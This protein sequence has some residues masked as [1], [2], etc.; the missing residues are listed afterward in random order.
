MLNGLSHFLGLDK[1]LF[2]YNCSLIASLVCNNR[3]YNTN[4]KISDPSKT[5]RKNQQVERILTKRFVTMFG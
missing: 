3:N 4:L 5:Q 1:N 2:L